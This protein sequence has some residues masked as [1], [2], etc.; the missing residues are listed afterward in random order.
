MYGV[1]MDQIAKIQ[2][3]GVGGSG[4]NAVNR[5]IESG[6]KGVELIVAYTD[7]QVLNTSRAEVKLQIG[8][9][10]TNGLGAGANPEVG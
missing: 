1:E 7:L 9:N 10:R 5:M 6:V 3:I 2:V 4:C 8:K